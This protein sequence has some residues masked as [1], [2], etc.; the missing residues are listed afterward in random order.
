MSLHGQHGSHHVAQDCIQLVRE[1]CEQRAHAPAPEGLDRRVSPAGSP[2]GAG[3]MDGMQL[4]HVIPAMR[5]DPSAAALMAAMPGP[6]P[7][8][9]LTTAGPMHRP[10][11]VSAAMDV[12]T[13][14]AAGALADVQWRV[15]AWAGRATRAM[16]LAHCAAACGC[17]QTKTRECTLLGRA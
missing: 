8:D 5:L 14:A 12:G 6:R 7:G 15:L 13:A 4:R 11:S 10:A 17:T 16:R 9:E 1:E 3:A 2:F